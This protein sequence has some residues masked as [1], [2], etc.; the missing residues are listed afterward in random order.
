MLSYDKLLQ[1][2]SISHP[3]SQ[4]YMNNFHIYFL[5]PLHIK[6]TDAANPNLIVT[7]HQRYQKIR[8]H[9]LSIKPGSVSAS[10]G[11]IYSDN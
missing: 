3:T 5:D 10:K 11:F 8:E 4:L 1:I 7:V 6:L 2:W 9:C